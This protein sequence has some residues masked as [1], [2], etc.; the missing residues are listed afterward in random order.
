MNNLKGVN[1]SENRTINRLL[2]SKSALFCFYINF[3]NVYRWLS[4][5]LNKTNIYF[6]IFVIIK[7]T[8]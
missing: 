8:I 3:E 7:L 2:A 6:I 1:R 4:R 5:W